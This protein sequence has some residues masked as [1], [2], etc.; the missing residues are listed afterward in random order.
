MQ[1]LLFHKKRI[2]A[3]LVKELGCV[4][5]AKGR[6][7]VKSILLLVLVRLGNTFICV[8]GGRPAGRVLRAVD[9]GSWC[10]NKLPAS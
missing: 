7:H 3:K 1:L 9:I 2:V 10:L 8:S 5:N 4:W 6:P